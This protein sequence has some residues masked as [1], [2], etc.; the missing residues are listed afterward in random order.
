MIQKQKDPN[1]IVLHHFSQSIAGPI[2]LSRFVRWPR[3]IIPSCDMISFVIGSSGSMIGALAVCDA[4]AA[5][6]FAVAGAVVVACHLFYCWTGIVAIVVVDWGW[7]LV[8]AEEAVE[9]GM[10]GD[11]D[12][13]NFAVVA[14]GVVVIVECVIDLLV[15]DS[16]CG[17]H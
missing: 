8:E 1:K 7:G 4:A 9:G 6:D 3:E 11:N 5:I 17:S 10:A 12:S 16:G 2:W 15:L 14:F 13:L